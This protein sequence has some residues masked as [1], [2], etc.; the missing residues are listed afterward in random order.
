[1]S[2]DPTL[3]VDED[4]VS[5]REALVAR[6]VER[7]A[8]VDIA[9]SGPV[10]TAIGRVPR[11][12]FTPDVP[13]VEAYADD[14]VRY[15]RDIDG[16]VLSSVSAPNMIALMLDQL[17][18]Q[19]G[20][21]VLEIGSGGY[22][23]ALIAELV[24]PTGRVIT[25]DI[26]PE[27][28]QRARAGLDAAGY[29]HVQTITADGE[30]SVADEAWFDR[31]V[32]TVESWD[33]APAWATQLARTGRLVVPLVVRGQTRSVAFDRHGNHLESFDHHLCGFVPMRG[34]GE[35]RRPKLAL[36]QGQITLRLD[37]GPVPH[38]AALDAALVGPAH[39]EWSGVTIGGRMPFDGLNLWLDV[40]QPRHGV[41]FAD[42]EPIT[43]GTVDRLAQWGTTA[44]F[45]D[46][47]IAHRA[48]RRV[49]P[50]QDVHEF[51]AIG[52][53]PDG[54]DLAAALVDQIRRWDTS[55]RHLPPP[56]LHAYPAGTDDNDL[57][58]G[59][60]IEKPHTRLVLSYV[61]HASLSDMDAAVAD[62]CSTTDE[63]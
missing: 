25:V 28:T 34:A 53:G 47:S 7:W 9:I 2:T 32:V 6:V 29:S 54:A 46:T 27:V 52:H 38:P 23:A 19:P 57:P 33:L 15:Q 41:L 11:H 56:S 62:H 58:P 20:H 1:M 48:I 18:L 51:G 50:A 37:H 61:P 26:D 40:T 43:A 12:L 59:I 3:T 5:L 24:G 39:V 16:T 45:T 44:I 10:L 63:S 35:H 4:P 36:R 17:A 22:N 31:I 60:T 30:F 8:T 14:I 55:V 42:P 49:D 13:L 21:R